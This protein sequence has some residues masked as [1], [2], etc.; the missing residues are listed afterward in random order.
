M[1]IERYELHLNINDSEYSYE[2]T[3]RIYLEGKDEKLVLNAVDLK[4]RNIWVNGKEVHFS[5][6]SANEELCIETA[7]NGKTIVD[8]EFSGNI[9][10]GL[11]GFYL[12]KTDNS[13]M[14]TT[15]FESSGAR[16]TFP[17][18]DHPAF[19]ASFSLS[20]TI[21]EGHDAISNMPVKLQRK[22]NGKKTVTFED[23][24]RMSTYLLY[25]G[26]GKFDERK[27]IYEDKE[28]ILLASKGHLTK[29]NIPF[30]IAK[31]SL[32]F[33]EDYFGIKYM[34]PKLHLISV[35]EFAAGA[36]ENWGAITFREVFLSIGN[37]TSARY[38]KLIA[39]V[40]AHEIAH[41][42]FGDLVTM[43]WWNDLWLNESFATF[44]SHKLVNEMFPEWDT[45]GDFLILRTE[46]A[47]KGDALVHSHP[48]DADVKDP[49]S[50][51]QIFD[52]ISYGKG[53]SILRM[54]ES[55]VGEDH[56]R[57]G[58]R[59]YLA[60]HSYK[61]AMG[62]D[63][64]NAIGKISE[65]PVH[66]IM[67][68]WIK[69][70]G[71]PLVIITRSGN[72]LHLKQEQFFLG[73][74]KSNDPWPI[75]LTVRR[76]TETESI[77]FE[78]E[79]LDIDGT[80]FLKLN[81]DQTGFYRVLYDEETFKNLL[82]RKQE[83]S[84]LDRWG[85]INDLYAFLISGRRDLGE[86]LNHIH[87]FD[88]ESNRL[89]VEE[90]SNQLSN[91]YLLLPNH[92][93]LVEFSKTF[94][95]KHLERLGEKKENESENDAILRGSI[96][97]ELA[98][99]DPEFAS[100]LS[101]KFSVFQDA[102]PDMR[103]AIALSEAVT[104]NHFLSLEEEFRSSH[105]DEDRTKLINA[106]GWLDGDENLTKVIELIRNEQIKKQDTPRFYISASTNPKAREF[107]L[108]RL[109][110][111]V[112][113]LQ[114]VFIGSGTTSRTLEQMIPLLGIGRESQIL[115]LVNKLRAPD[116]ETGIKKGIEFLQVYSKFVNRYTKQS[117][118][119]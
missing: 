108:R 113:Q 103:S 85:M 31:R 92:L 46:A 116:T 32:R 23:T 89:V 80:D 72:K 110:F 100:T 101:R 98:I 45:W 36:M 79:G 6:N 30:D 70:K 18:V 109:E 84:N 11:T 87:A 104:N 25:I 3:E 81:T 91:L 97:A 40:I 52:E 34:L 105:N 60:E 61:N 21:H 47:L 53:G 20:L 41:H 22:E 106:M 66:R 102:D 118:S 83:L 7:I 42:W 95:T 112:R 67:E 56:F 119:P 69:R 107:M 29:S 117:R 48:I 88:N 74:G 51:A 73:D 49:N 90:I 77:L 27:E 26:V 38:R 63:L 24:P 14:F 39:E 99:V 94:F 10:K 12:A 33:F 16:R 2:G 4:I 76:K 78:G 44:M 13:E 68:A 86:Y 115:D 75:P 35:P 114:D 54:I 57:D 71:Y 17:C 1:K 64:W 50:V 19:K 93:N 8:L 58:I 5:L 96:S 111:A 65:Q 28:V 37:S 82:S 9:S 43:K 55:Y 62:A 59:Y 15:Q